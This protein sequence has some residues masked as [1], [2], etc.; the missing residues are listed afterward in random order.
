V[1]QTLS[2]CYGCHHCGV[3]KDDRQPNSLIVCPSNGWMMVTSLD[4]MFL[5][6][7]ALV[8]GAPPLGQGIK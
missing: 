1:N 3:A 7:G 2:M 4:A 5:L 6:R 8:M